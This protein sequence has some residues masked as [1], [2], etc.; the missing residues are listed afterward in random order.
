MMRV[1]RDV[2]DRKFS[3]RN[4][5]HEMKYKFNSNKKFLTST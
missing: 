3:E 2:S 1:I 5:T 4:N